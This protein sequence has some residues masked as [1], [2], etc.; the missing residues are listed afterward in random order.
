M[1][2][3]IRTIL[4]P[5]DFSEHAAAA[6]EHAAELA[7][8]FSARVVLLHSYGVAISSL[9]AN[10]FV[11]PGPFVEEVVAEAR[12]GLEELQKR[13][14]LAALPCEVQLA[15]LPVVTAILEAAR[16]LPAD[17]I[18]MGTQG[19]SGLAHAL[20]GSVAE[21]TVRL[22]HCPVLTVRAQPSAAPC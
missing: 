3:P 22:A 13:P 8:H 4:V 19:R 11:M 9:S 10:P 18:V 5:T 16:A 21:R 1:P 2:T 14:S 20:L 17:L 12:A 7:K 6:L 15:P